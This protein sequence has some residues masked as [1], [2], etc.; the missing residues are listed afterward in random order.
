MT[1]NSP[2]G[3]YRRLAALISGVSL[4]MLLAEPVLSIVSDHIDEAFYSSCLPKHVLDEIATYA[5]LGYEMPLNPKQA[6]DFILHAWML[7][8]VIFT[9]FADLLTHGLD[10]RAKKLRRNKHV[11]WIFRRCGCRKSNCATT[12]S[13]TAVSDPGS[14]A[15]I[16][17]GGRLTVRRFCGCIQHAQGA[18]EALLPVQPGDRRRS[19]QNPFSHFCLHI[20]EA[21]K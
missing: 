20:Y 18:S 3:T 17:A 1:R 19:K 15:P 9:E 5:I 2:T 8:S 13:S 10:K 4:I 11:A 16:G 21:F 14:A 12:S 7:P 6:A